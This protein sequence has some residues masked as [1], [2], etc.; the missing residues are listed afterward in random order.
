MVSSVGDRT[1]RQAQLTFAMARHALV[2]LSQV[3]GLE[4]VAPDLD[5]LPE[6]SFRK[7]HDLLCQ[8]GVKVARNDASQVRLREMRALY[9]PYAECMSRYLSMPMPPFISDRPRKDNWLTVAKVQSEARA[10]AQV[11]HP[12]T[13]IPHVDEEHE[14]EHHIF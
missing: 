12:L 14:E 6:P 13:G 2:D 5:R 10:A 9:E 7:L 3:F 8:V 4:P 1:G 11:M